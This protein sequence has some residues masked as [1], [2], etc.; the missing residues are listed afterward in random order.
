MSTRKPNGDGND[1]SIPRSGPSDP[2][3]TPDPYE[4]EAEL[5]DMASPSSPGTPEDPDVDYKPTKRFSVGKTARTHRVREATRM[6]MRELRRRG[7]DLD[8]G[9][10]E[11]TALRVVAS[12]I[13][14]SDPVY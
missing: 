7:T 5:A 8:D 1:L 13:P 9:Q 10:L 4:H 6:V 12:T 3:G 2:L 14:K 11:E